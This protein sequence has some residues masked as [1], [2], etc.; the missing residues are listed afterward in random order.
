MNA[1]SVK[2]C[3]SAGVVLAITGIA[4]LISGFGNA[5]ILDI[6]DPIFGFRFRYF[7]LVVGLLELSITYIC[8]FGR[9]V[10]LSLML[11]AWIATNFFFYRLGLWYMEWSRPCGCLGNIT[12]ILHISA[13]AAENILKCILAYLLIGSYTFLIRLYYHKAHK[14]ECTDTRQ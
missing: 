10:R 3:R 6:H 14:M 12:D 7:M 4:K 5:E 9:N 1:M 11:V 13:S 2:F 8:W